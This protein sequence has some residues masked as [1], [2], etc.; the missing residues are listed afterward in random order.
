ML[1]RV[2]VGN[3]SVVG[4]GAVV[5]KDVELLVVMVGNPAKVVKRI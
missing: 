3:G 1:P 4:V 2:T 5:T